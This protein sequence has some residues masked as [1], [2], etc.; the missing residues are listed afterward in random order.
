MRPG[1]R[2][3][4]LEDVGELLGVGGGEVLLGLLEE[5]GAEQRGALAGLRHPI[6]PLRIQLGDPVPDQLL[7]GRD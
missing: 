7:Q 5:L 1:E 4:H 2:A 3:H 6:R